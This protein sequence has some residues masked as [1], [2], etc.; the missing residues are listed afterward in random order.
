MIG[1]PT[2][3]YVGVEL[4]VGRYVLETH[5]VQVLNEPQSMGRPVRAV[6]CRVGRTGCLWVASVSIWITELCVTPHVTTGLP[7]ESTGG[8][9]RLKSNLEFGIG[10]PAIGVCQEFRGRSNFCS[11][12]R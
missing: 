9:P 6:V 3:T 2:R 8:D 7:Q 4:G 12:F 1:G 11:E 5:A 10:N